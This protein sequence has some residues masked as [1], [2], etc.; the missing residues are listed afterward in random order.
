MTN[1]RAQGEGVGD[2]IVPPL[3]GYSVYKVPISQS[4]LGFPTKCE[5]RGG[6]K[7]L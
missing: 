1:K 2:V 6:S 7:A 5:K 3:L 4:T